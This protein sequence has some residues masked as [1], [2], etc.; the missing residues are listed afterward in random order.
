MGTPGPLEFLKQRLAARPDSEHGQ[1]LIRLAFVS[2][3]F[4]YFFTDFFA[5][6]VDDAALQG[7]RLLAF[8]SITCSALIF[9]CIV[10]WP[11]KSVVRRFVGMF[12]DVTAIS[13]AMYFGEGA[14]AAIAV[15]YLWITVGNGFR[16]GVL[17]LYAC[18]GL[19]ISGFAIV[20]GLG[21]Y[22]QQQD[23]LSLNILLVMLVVPPYVGSLLRSLHAA[24]DALQ[25]QAST[26][27]LT[28]LLS[29]TEME[30]AVDLLFH[31][32][33]EGHVLLFCDLD[34]FKEVNDVAG[35]AAG[36]KLLSDLGEIIQAS[37]RRDDLSAR[38]GGDEFCVLLRHCSLERGREVAEKI[39]SKVTGYR[40][41]WGTEYFSVGVSIG[42][43][44]SDAV[45]DAESLFRL[46]DAAC[47]AAKNAGRNRV[48]VIDPRTDLLETQKIRQLFDDAGDERRS[49]GEYTRNS[50]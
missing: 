15:I 23:L 9:L 28:G 47:Y 29:R 38:M 31:G 19:S 26:D 18:A 17:Y 4:V 39:R 41:A 11:S 44:P 24:K 48:H 7:A 45:H 30:N 35:H 6:R 13:L 34:R 2:I 25:H 1:A 10:L 5:G 32:N 50:Y 16:Y 33:S 43:A 20:Y 37:V 12:H 42:V 3:V 21:E 40:L 49:D 36:D 8:S 22:W 46:A 14:G 27:A